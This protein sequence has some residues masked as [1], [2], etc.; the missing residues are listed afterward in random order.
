[1]TGRMQS[2]AAGVIALG[3][4]GLLSLSPTLAQRPARMRQAMPMYDTQTEATLR[5]TVEEVKSVSG[6]MA[7]AGRMGM[8]GSGMEGTHVV[9]K[10]ADETIEVHLGPT[11][12]LKEQRVEL[13]KGDTVEVTGS[14]VTIGDSEALLAREIRK[15]ETSWTFR[16]ANGRP[17]WTRMQR[18]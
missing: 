4:V 1:M 2:L 11:A 12:F 16:S 13:A 17:L 14:R 3:A 6:R 10:T 7:G 8:P 9:L 18:Q 15:G 5:G